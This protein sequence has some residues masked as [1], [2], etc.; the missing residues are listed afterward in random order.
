MSKTTDNAKNCLFFWGQASRDAETLGIA[1]IALSVGGA[2]RMVEGLLEEIDR[3]RDEL[4]AASS[5]GRQSVTATEAERTALE[6]A[7]ASFDASDCPDA[8]RDADMLR[9]LSTRLTTRGW[10]PWSNC[11][12]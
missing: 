6:R 1:N 3:L 12:L 11:R 7:I 8:N 2:A 5:A 9:S 10:P 4:S